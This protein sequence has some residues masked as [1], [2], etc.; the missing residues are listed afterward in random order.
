MLTSAELKAHLREQLD[1][2]AGSSAAYDAGAKH[3]AKRIAAVIRTL[4]HHTPKSHALLSQLGAEKVLLM[5]SVEPLPPPV[6]HPDGTVSFVRR[7]L[8]PLI[9]TKVTSEG[10]EIVPMLD[11][12]GYIAFLPACD[13]WSELLWEEPVRMTRRQLVLSAANTDGGSHVA[14]KGPAGEYGGAYSAI[15]PGLVWA[16]RDADRGREGMLENP[17]YA[18]LRQLAHELLSSPELCAL[19]A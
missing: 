11:L 1:F 15:K 3:E 6:Q 4:L 12:P 14:P 10:V 9:V 13:W 7:M 8:S 19:A 18:D 5:T 16:S 2:L 17:Q